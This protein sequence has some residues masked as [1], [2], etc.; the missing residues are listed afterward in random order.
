M[1]EK[2]K[3]ILDKIVAW[4]KKFTSKQKMLIVSLTAVVMLALVILAVIMSIPETTELITC[5]STAE[6][7]K[8]K[9]LLEG[10][11]IEAEVSNDGLTFT[12]DVADEAAAN[13]LLGANEIAATEPS[14]DDVFS[15]GFGTTEA[16]KEKLYK[17]YREERFASFLETLENVEEASV[18]LEVPP[19]DGTIISREQD[20]YVAVKL[21]L[22]GEMTEEQAAG[23]AQ[24]LAVSVGN[25]TTEC[26]Q[27][28]DT[29][30]NVL[31][32]GGDSTTS[33]GNASS[34][35]SY[36]TKKENNMKGE[37]REIL[38]GTNV[39]DAVSV[40]L[41]LKLDFNEV[42]SEDRHVYVDE[43][44]EQGY[45]TSESVYESSST[46]GVSGVPGTDSNDD[47][48]T[49]V[50]EDGE[51]TSQEITD[52]TTNY[53]P[54]VKV[55]KTKEEVGEIIPEESSITVVAT[56]HVTYSEEDMKASGQLEDMTFDEFRIQNSEWIQT[57]T[58]EELYEMVANATGIAIENIS[59]VTYDVPIFD[60]AEVDERT[61]SDYLQIA[62]AV[63]ILALLGYVVFRSTRKE[64]EPEME[65]ELS[66]ESLL[67][68]TKE[69]EK[70]DLED[71]G[72]SEK[73][74]TRILI[75][76]FVDENPEAVAALMRNWLNEEWN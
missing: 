50:I 76:K 62:L 69:A 65:P 70:E 18:S 74:E 32:A 48:P 8:V 36:Q 17:A 51:V 28:I 42:E 6:A 14:I 16:D 40:G 34:Q 4:W 30:G 1:P 3:Q 66:V 27:I 60:P 21:K 45:I 59:I 55:T 2:I 44:K 63:L 39:Y 68:T 46:G 7:S 72:Y 20:T 15:G 75:E 10:E 12:I 33:V 67:E 57:E 53:D 23:I 54:S 11:G 41:N 73:S 71:I 38:M 52:R 43:G 58:N 47:T 22:Q 37:V 5:S 26:V 35:L 64:Q 61:L 49:Y 13:M 56:N 31:F 9:D 24:Y 29:T 19:D 25:D